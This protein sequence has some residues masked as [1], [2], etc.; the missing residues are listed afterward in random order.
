MD[1]M[2]T[3][4]A[5]SFAA[6]LASARSAIGAWAKQVGVSAIQSVYSQDQESEADRLAVYLMRAAGHDGRAA[7]Q[8]M[9]ALA[10][11]FL[12]AWSWRTGCSTSASHPPFRERLAAIHRLLQQ[13]G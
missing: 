3:H 7:G 13:G 6:G 12:R 2:M 8:L 10:G 5:V 1:R 9:L 11:H 4:S